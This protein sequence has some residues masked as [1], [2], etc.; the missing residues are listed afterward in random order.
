VSLH[1][2]SQQVKPS[3]PT[4]P[5]VSRSVRARLDE[6]A[7]PNSDG[8]KHLKNTAGLTL[9]TPQ[10]DMVP[11]P[12]PPEIIRITIDEQISD[13]RTAL[14]RQQKQRSESKYKEQLKKW[15]HECEKL[16][17]DL[18]GLNRMKAQGLGTDKI[19][20]VKSLMR[21]GGTK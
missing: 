10:E 6:W 18:W 9:V 14:T 1:V 4:T 12:R 19:V 7:V 2:C 5:E 15:Q 3:I 13:L 21:E 8:L 16:R 11:P 17:A 20:E